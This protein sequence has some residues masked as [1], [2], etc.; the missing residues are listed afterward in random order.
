MSQFF[1][2][3]SGGSTPVTVVE[4]LTGNSGVATA[5]ANNINTP[6]NNTANNGYATWT[7][8]SGDT[9]Q[10]KSYGTA[11][12]VVNPVAGLGTHQTIQAA[13]NAASP[14][15]TIAI[16]SGA[17]TENLTLKSGLLFF[18]Y[19]TESSTR[20]IGKIADGGTVVSCA[21]YNIEIITNND[22]F[23]DVSGSGTVI[24]FFNSF[25]RVQDHVGMRVL[26]GA[27]VRC[28]GCQGDISGAAYSMYDL[29]STGVIFFRDCPSLSNSSNSTVIATCPGNVQFQ[30]SN[31]NFGVGSTGTGE[32]G[33][34]NCIIDL[35]DL[36]PAQATAITFNGSSSS[37]AFFC[38]I[39]TG[40]QTAISIGASALVTLG[41]LQIDTTATNAISGTG[42]LFYNNLSF[43]NS[44][45]I[46]VTSEEPLVSSN[47]CIE[48][49][50]PGA[51]PYT[52]KS[53]DAFIPVDSSAARTINLPASPATGQKHTI[54]DNGGLAGTNNITIVP[55][56]GN[57]D[58][59][60][61]YVINVNY[62]SV[63]L[64]YNSTQWNVR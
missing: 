48:V 14:G 23:L 57:I 4:T 35:S 34:Y 13:I 38:T 20:F 63:D 7:T 12:W 10:I 19:G 8:G 54:K 44:S 17:Y 40:N 47:D 21:F 58:G 33:I 26:T 49:A 29:N 41:H 25:L 56:A 42:Q 22:Y 55:A 24:K 32:I 28:D 50:I 51:Y 18:G 52:V 39:G 64:V 53:Q 60:A 30:N 45:L 27:T 15:D 37:G 36:T 6:G 43:T 5:A 16:T 9:L 59:A 62:G 31:F 61:S 2:P 11:K 3:G 46:S 1:I